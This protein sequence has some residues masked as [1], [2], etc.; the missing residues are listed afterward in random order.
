MPKG[1]GLTKPLK[2]SPDLADILGKKEA[3]RAECIKLLWAYLKKNDL[4]DPN[5]KQYFTPDKKL[6]KVKN[7]TI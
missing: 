6:A 3:S 2:V 5:N 1:E 4:L 7:A